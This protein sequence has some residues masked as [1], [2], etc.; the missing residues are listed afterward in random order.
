MCSGGEGNRNVR[1]KEN[2]LMKCPDYPLDELE[3]TRHLVRIP[4]PTGEEKRVMEYLKTWLGKRGFTVLEQEVSP[5]RSNLLALN[6]EPRVVLSTHTDTVSPYLQSG[7]D[8]D[9]I[10]GRGACDTRGI[11]AAMLIAG[12]RLLCR[13]TGNFGILLLVGEEG[14]HDG[15]KRAN[16]WAL[17]QECRCLVNGEPTENRMAQASLGGLLVNLTTHGVACHSGMPG[18]GHSAVH[19]LLDILNALREI[20]LPKNEIL[21]ESSMN[22]GRIQG[23]VQ[24]NIMA[25]EAQCDLMF[26]LVEDP[27]KLSARIREVVAERGEIKFLSAYPPVFL[28]TLADFP[29]MVAPFGTDIPFLSNWGDAFLIGPGSISDAHSPGEKVEKSQIR[30]AVPLYM[31]LVER[32]L[33]SLPR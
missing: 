32:L 31:G 3:L 4:S 9:F 16:A 27:E 20:S 26:R 6:G 33:E 24:G 15:A 22:V 17:S 2:A 25:P 12:Y 18:H 29:T 5:G 1:K 11:L 28:H 10:Y 7:E 14:P 19:D 30:A 8:E 23:G 13:G 21:G